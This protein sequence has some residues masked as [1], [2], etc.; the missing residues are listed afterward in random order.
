[1]AYMVDDVGSALESNSW[2]FARS[3]GDKPHWYTL[4]DRWDSPIS[5]DDVVK[6]IRAQGTPRKFFRATF[7]YFK[8]GNHE[9]WTMGSP[10]NETT[11]INRA[12]VGPSIKVS[13]EGCFVSASNSTFSHI[14]AQALTLK[15]AHESLKKSKNTFRT[16]SLVDDYT[17]RVKHFFDYDSFDSFLSECGVSPVK[18]YSMSELSTLNSITVSKIRDSEI[19]D[20]Y[21]KHISS[22]RRHPTELSLATWYLLRLGVIDYDTPIRPAKKLLN[23]IP[24][25]LRGKYELALKI[26]EGVAG[27][28]TLSRIEEV[29]PA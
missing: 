24:D 13:L 12:Y 7:T 3:M 20:E 6:F 14:K 8:Y 27:D 23:I 10:V 15:R 17:Q 2:V 1:M 28:K 25:S 19:R 21:R 26:V 9:Y 22:S 11:L 5:F 18:S 4:R 16:V 29:S